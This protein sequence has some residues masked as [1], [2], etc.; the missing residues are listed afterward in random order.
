MIGLW[1]DALPCESFSSEVIICGTQS[2]QNPTGRDEVATDM[3][4]IVKDNSSHEIFSCSDALSKEELVTIGGKSSIYFH[5]TDLNNRL[6]FKTILA[7]RLMR[8]YIVICRWL[9][10][11]NT[12]QTSKNKDSEDNAISFFQSSSARCQRTTDL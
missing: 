1:K 11:R 6:L 7:C 9:D 8:N 5:A 12:V 2:F 3:V 4:Y 10:Q